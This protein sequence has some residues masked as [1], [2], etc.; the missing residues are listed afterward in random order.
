MTTK[1]FNV[2]LTLNCDPDRIEQLLEA[3]CEVCDEAEAM[4]TQYRYYVPKNEQQ[5]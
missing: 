4:I 1:Q 3:F 2:D 5:S